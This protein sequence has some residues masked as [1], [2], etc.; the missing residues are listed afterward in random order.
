MTI[1]VVISG[2]GNMGRAV[3]DGV[4]RA[5]GMEPVGMLEGLAQPGAIVGEKGILNKLGDGG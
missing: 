2:T 4:E 1:R 3:L 5:D